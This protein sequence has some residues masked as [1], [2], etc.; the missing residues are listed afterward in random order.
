MRPTLLLAALSIAAILSVMFW[1]RGYIESLSFAE[2]KV[3]S[4]ETTHEK[5]LDL[6]T[7]Q[8]NLLTTL[9]SALLAGL[10]AVLLKSESGP[11]PAVQVALLI[12]AVILSGASLYF[13]Y[14]AY[15]EVLW[16]LHSQFFNLEEPHIAWVRRLQFFTFFGSA[17][18]SLLFVAAWVST[19]PATPAQ[20]Q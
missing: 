4:L 6:F 20:A 3:S 13:G 17:L 18:F 7:E 1:E 16:M 14:L 10:G 5:Q 15:Q 9:A 2:I 19:R 8:A 11:I 12:A